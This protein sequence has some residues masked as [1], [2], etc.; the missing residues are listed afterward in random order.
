MGENDV[1]IKVSAQNSSPEINASDN[2]TH[3]ILKARSKAKFHALGIK[4]EQTQEDRNK[5]E[6]K[7][8][9]TVKNSGETDAHDVVVI[10]YKSDKQ[11]KDEIIG[12]VPIDSLNAGETKEVVYQWKATKEDLFKQF[13]PTFQIGLKASAQ[14]ISNVEE[15]R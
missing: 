3:K 7:L 1:F 2:I 11:T 14:R 6:A 5:F 13:H 4:I 9:A 15:Q 12:E 10:F 8:I